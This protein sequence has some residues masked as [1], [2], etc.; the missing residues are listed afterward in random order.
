MCSLLGIKHAGEIAI[1]PYGFVKWNPV[2]PELVY[3]IFG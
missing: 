3:V 2:F 1:V